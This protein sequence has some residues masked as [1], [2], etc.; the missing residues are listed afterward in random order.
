M[1]KTH[2]PDPAIRAMISNSAKIQIV[3]PSLA[4]TPELFGSKIQTGPVRYSVPAARFENPEAISEFLDRAEVGT[5]VRSRI[6]CDG[7]V[8]VERISKS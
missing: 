4:E 6:V 5:T 8:R 7:P 2:E 1:I 3:T